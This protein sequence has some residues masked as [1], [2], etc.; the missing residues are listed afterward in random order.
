MPEITGPYNQTS[1]EVDLADSAVRSKLSLGV[2][3]TPPHYAP[4]YLYDSR[5]SANIRRNSRRYGHTRQ[6]D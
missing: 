3:V 1:W 6:W 2:L 5:D 4:I